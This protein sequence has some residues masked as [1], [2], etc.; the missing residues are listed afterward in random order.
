M[1]PLLDAAFKHAANM[2]KSL[3]RGGLPWLLT[4]LGPALGTW[5][6]FS[7][8]GSPLLAC[9][10]QDWT[11]HRAGIRF[12]KSVACRYRRWGDDG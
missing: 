1:M 8:A 10:I 12:T 2:P 5:L 4:F 6:A 7:L 9:L 11:S 3:H